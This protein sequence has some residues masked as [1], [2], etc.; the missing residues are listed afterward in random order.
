MQQQQ[1]LPSEPA[2]SSTWYGKE[3]E[4]E[5]IRIVYYPTSHESRCAP[6][7][8]DSNTAQQSIQQAQHHVSAPLISGSAHTAQQH[9]PH[10]HYSRT[11]LSGS[12]A[13]QQPIRHSSSVHTTSLRSL[14]VNQAEPL[15]HS[16]QHC[17]TLHTRCGVANRCDVPMMPRGSLHSPVQHNSSLETSLHNP[18]T[19]HNTALATLM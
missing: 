1:R 11:C 13:E 6:S 3:R 4:A 17:T 9:Q 12:S 10:Y 19:Q 7:S 16:T 15:I 5:T 2:A 8:T 14:D 18:L